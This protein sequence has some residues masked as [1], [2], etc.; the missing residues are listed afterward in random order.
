MPIPISLDGGIAP[1]QGTSCFMKPLVPSIQSEDS[2]LK[3]DNTGERLELG[4]GGSP[5]L[6]GRDDMGEKGAGRW[7][8]LGLGIGKGRGSWGMGPNGPSSFLGMSSG[9]RGCPAHG[10][11]VDREGTEGSQ[12]P[13]TRWVSVPTKVGRRQYQLT[14]TAP[15]GQPSISPQGEEAGGEIF[16]PKHVQIR[17]GSTIKQEPGGDSNSSPSQLQSEFRSKKINQFNPGS[18]RVP[19]LRN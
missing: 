18:I 12:P 4:E 9:N 10:A 2:V 5:I 19:T 15:S 11:A 14:F 8:L 7:F 17:P 3:T 1:D 16:S 13:R 6:E